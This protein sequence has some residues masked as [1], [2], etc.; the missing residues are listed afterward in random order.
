[1]PL[2]HHTST[3]SSA[4]KPSRIGLPPCCCI[5]ISFAADALVVRPDFDREIGE[6]D[7]AGRLVPF[8]A[9]H[10]RAVLR[11]GERRALESELRGRR[12]RPDLELLLLFHGAGFHQQDR[13]RRGERRGHAD[14]LR[15]RG[16][17]RHLRDQRRAR[18]ADSGD[19]RIGL[20]GRVG[21]G[22]RR[23]GGGRGVWVR[24]RAAGR[25][26]W[27]P[28]TGGGAVTVGRGCPGRRSRRPP[29]G[30]GYARGPR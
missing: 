15:S 9:D 20:A 1:M 18:L 5:G 17:G 8:R 24:G 11:L 21:A 7:D 25:G 26:S 2:S 13:V 27:F 23:G 19:E 30:G 6:L 14:Q 22:R 12:E 4:R 10:V 16:D 3:L 28:P 29:A